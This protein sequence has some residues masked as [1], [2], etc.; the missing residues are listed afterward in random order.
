MQGYFRVVKPN[1]HRFWDGV[2]GS[3]INVAFNLYCLPWDKV[4]VK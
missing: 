1:Y 2:V 4:N 3:S